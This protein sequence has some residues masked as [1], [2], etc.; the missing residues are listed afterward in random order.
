[1]QSNVQDCRFEASHPLGRREESSAQE[2]GRSEMT[3]AAGQ[4]VG[5]YSPLL[6]CSPNRHGFFFLASRDMIISPSEN[7]FQLT[8]I[9]V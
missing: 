9:T 8:V 2:V 6:K 1:M 5:R 3:T 7:V 4:E